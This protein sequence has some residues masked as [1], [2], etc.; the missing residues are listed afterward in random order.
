MSDKAIRDYV[1]GKTYPSLDRIAHI[2]EVTGCSF[3]WLAT[4]YDITESTSITT[5]REIAPPSEK[6][7]QAWAEILERMTPIERETVLDNVY[8]QGINTL[9]RSYQDTANQHIQSPHQQPEGLAEKLGIS[10]HALTVARL[11]E[12]LTEEERKSFLETFEEEKHEKTSLENGRKNKA[13]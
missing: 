12:E 1:G 10:N 4:G 13:S 3:E 7:H 2:A 6:Q 9:I 8:R 5:G 11:F